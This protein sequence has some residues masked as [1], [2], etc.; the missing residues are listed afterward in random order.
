VRGVGAEGV[1]D[2]DDRQMGMLLAV[3]IIVSA[4]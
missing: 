2:D 3:S 1:F 4:V